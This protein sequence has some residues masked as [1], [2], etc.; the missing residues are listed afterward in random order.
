MQDADINS[1]T[2][3]VDANVT[4]KLKQKRPLINLRAMTHDLG[5]KVN[6]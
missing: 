5:R 1:I 6:E 4:Q 2:V 3:N